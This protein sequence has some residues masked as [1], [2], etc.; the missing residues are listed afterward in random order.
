MPGKHQR[1]LSGWFV[2]RAGL[3]R[4]TTFAGA[5]GLA[6]AAISGPRPMAALIGLILALLGA[7]SGL[8]MSRRP[9]TDGVRPPLLVLIAVVM[10]GLFGGY[11]GGSAR[12]M[13][14]LDSSLQ[15]R[16]GSTIVAEL[17]VTGQLRSNAGWQSAAAVIRGP[18]GPSAGPGDASA[19]AVAAVGETV[20]VEI[21]PAE[22]PSGVTLSQGL[23]VAFR[24]TIQEPEGPSA[25]G[26]DQGA[27]LRRQGIR[28]VLSAD[29]SGGVTI[30]GRRGG[31]SGWFDR[32]RSAA[33]DH[34]SRGPDARLDEVLNGVV[35]GDADGI[36]KGWLEA[37]RRSGTAHMLSVGGMHM[38]S[39]AAIIL[40]LA[41]L[42][43]ASRGVGFLLAAAG[44]LLM[45]PLVGASPPVVR[46]AVMIVIVLAGSWAGR[47]MDRW[48]ILALA[49]LVVLA[50]NPFDIADVGFQLTFAAIAGMLALAGP[51]QRSMK[52]VPSAISSNLA[53]SIA[54]S[55]GTAPVSLLVFDQ[56]SLV[57]PLANLLVV[58][59]LPVITGLG[60]ASVFL[61][62]LWTGFS[63]ALDFLASLPMTW[64]VQVSRLFAAAPVLE[65]RALGR[66]LL[67]AGVGAAAVPAGLA[68]M[69]RAVGTPFNLPAPLFKRSI[70]WLRA[71]RPRSRRR[72]AVLS[73]AIVC[74]GLLLGGVAYSPLVRGVETVV[75][76][77]PGNAWPD[78]VEVRVLDVG[79]GNAVL[80]RTPGHRALLFDG[81]P[82]GS[83][84]ARQ[85]HTLGVRTLDLA[86]IS[87]PH[88]DHFAGLLEAIGGLEVGTLVDQT[89]VVPRAPPTEAARQRAGG[90]Q[91]ATGY[92]EL[93][94]RIGTQGGQYVQG[95][96][97]SV[98]DVDGVTVR[99]FAPSRPLSLV[100]G[101]DPWAGRSGPPTG[102]ELNGSSLV[103]VLSA[104]S[105][106]VLLPGDAEAEVLLA[107]KLPPIDVIVVPHHGSRGS[108]SAGLLGDLGVKAACISV[109]EGNS[110]GHPDPSTMSILQA[111]VG[112]ALRTDEAGWVSC[113]VNGDDAM[114]ATERKPEQ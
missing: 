86:V 100:D 88:A 77:A 11:L 110:F 112:S 83:D 102:D 13:A 85:L 3:A 46:S 26:F 22:G 96:T 24:G 89:V 66:A 90:P 67:A 41:R 74:A 108:V 18:A 81:G 62:F 79:Q 75:A 27:Y 70:G 31:I 113:T 28:V 14:L 17:V 49:A 56:T 47:R 51:L 99:F 106:D 32:L 54:A 94:R 91:E 39:I 12:V 23:I 2:R 59:L 8:L 29:G 36:D 48:Q 104:G 76:L 37:F 55:L 15:R 30:L 95:G 34:L 98:I 52:R 64:T 73:I 1:D 16:V 109:G 5:L 58:P 40:G 63:T 45:V 57:G 97:G 25:S 6:L 4:T 9:S 87:H 19:I 111:A 114:L 10:V 33:R 42:V 93:R 71:R 80:V 44:A 53:V 43:R 107:Y 105:V 78:R 20:L 38:A 65:M 103:A 101:P 68:L 69:G 92:L 50:L 61:G 7:L 60:M 21:A 82:A 35:M 84:L 72:A